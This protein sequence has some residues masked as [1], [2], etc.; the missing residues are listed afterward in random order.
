MYKA[1]LFD[2]DGTLLDT[3]E[4][5]ISSVKY[6]IEKMGLPELSYDVLK[7]FVGPPIKKKMMEM[8]ELSDEVASEAMNIFREHYGA[9]DIYIAK[10]YDGMIALLDDLKKR[11]YK[12]GVATYKREDQAK[13][14]LEKFEIADKFDV[15]HGSDKEGM[16]TKADVI[17]N[18]VRELGYSPC[19]MVLIGDSDNDAIGAKQAGL[20]FIGVTYGYGFKSKADVDC[21]QNMGIA[22]ECYQISELINR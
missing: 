3:G 8:F 19:E 20:E 11:G 13:K 6:T 5:V 17:N 4:G 2:L 22:E 18:C 14:L 16:L 9:G 1:V 15:I 7:T 10:V 12:L 21:F